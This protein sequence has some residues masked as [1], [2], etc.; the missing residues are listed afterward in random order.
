MDGL[1]I[2]LL[3]FNHASDQGGL[4]DFHLVDENRI[5]QTLQKTFSSWIQRLID[6]YAL[7]STDTEIDQLDTLIQQLF[8]VC[9][10]RLAKLAEFLEQ[11]VMADATDLYSL[12]DLIQRFYAKLPFWGIPPLLIE[13]KPGKTLLKEASAFI[14]HQHFKTPSEQ[15]KAWAKLDKALNENTLEIPKT[16][17][18]ESRY[19]DLN[20]FR[21]TLRAFIFEA[22]ANAR[23][24]LLQTDL[25]PVLYILKQKVKAEEDQPPKTEREQRLSG[26]SLPVLLQAVWN[27]LLQYQ[28]QTQRKGQSGFESLERIRIV[29]QR[30]N[31]DLQNDDSGGGIGREEQAQQLIRGCL[32]GLATWFADDLDARLPVDPEQ[33]QRRRDDWERPLPITLHLDAI[34]FGVSRAR[35]HLQFAV[36]LD[37][38]DGIA[39]F[40]RLFR[41]SFGPTQA[42]R[43]RYACAQTIRLRWADQA[44][45]L[46]PAFQ[47]PAVVMTAL[48]F[49]ADEDEAQRLISQALNEIVLIDQL[50]GQPAQTDP[51]LKQQTWQLIQTYRAWLDSYLDHGY[52]QALRDHYLPLLRAYRTLAEQVLDPARTG[53]AELLRRFYKAFLVINDQAQP[54]DAYLRSAIVWG[55]SPPLIELTHAQTRFL[56]DSF[57]EVIAELALNR[58]GQAAF[59]QLLNLAEIHRPLAGLVIDP[60]RALSPAI[61]SFGLLHHLGVAPSP[62]KSLAVQTLLRDD[63]SDDDDDI[64]DLVR[65]REESAIV[66]R[67]LTDY[68]ALYPF[69]QD[70]LRILAVHVQQLA[71]ILSGVDRFLRNYLQRTASDWPAFHCELTVYSTSSSP[72]AVENRLAAW[73]EAVIETTSRDEKVRP[74]AL[75]VSHR[76][77]PTRAQMVDFIQQ[78]RRLYDI[79]FLFHFMASDLTGDIEPTLP[80]AFNFNPHNISPFPIGEYPRPIQQGDAL[81]RQSLLSHRRLLI[82]T[83]HANLSARL[84]HPQMPN[85]D[86]LI[87]GHT[88][89]QPWQP[90]VQALHQKAQWVACIDPYVDKRLVGRHAD[91]SRRKIVGFSSGLGA[92]GELN[93]AISTEQDTLT[94]LTALVQNHLVGLMPFQSS[95]AFEAMAAKVVNEAEEIIGLSSLRAVVGQGERIREVV[96]FAAIRRALAT[97]TV[98]MSQLLPVDTLLHWF[99]GSEDGQ[100]PDLLQLSLIVR[101]NG[102]P[103]IQALV[104]EC[105]FAQYDPTHLQKASQQV[106][107][108]LRHFTRRFAPNRPDSGR[109]S[110]D[111]RYWWAQLQRALTSRSVVA[112]SQQERGQLDQ[113]L[114]SLAEGYYEIAWQGAIFTFWTDIAGSTPVVTPIPLPAGVLEPPLQAPQGFALWHIALGYEGV[115]AL[116]GDAPTFAPITIDPVAVTL[117]P[118]NGGK[119]MEDVT[120]PVEPPAVATLLVEPPAVATLPVE[121]SRRSAPPLLSQGGEKTA[122]VLV[123][124]PSSS[125]TVPDQL[126]IGA[127]SNG[128][129]VYWHYGHPQLAN[130]H[131]LIF[132]AT[133]VGKTYGVQCLLAEMAQQHLRS[134]IIDYTDGF[135][136]S[137]IEPLFRQ[138]AKPQDHFVVSHKLPL[139]PFRQQQQVIDPSQPAFAETPFHTATRIAS[140]F[141]SVFNTMGDQ[142]SSTLIRVLETGIQ[143]DPQLT[144]DEVLARL[145]DD[146][147]YG[148]TLASKLEPL[149]R[150]QPFRPGAADSAWKEMLN[151]PER[152]VHV[153][154]LKGLAREIQ[155]LVTEFVLWDLYDY[156][157]NTGSK[158]CPIPV[159]LD[160]IQNLDHRSDSPIDKMLREGRKFGLSLILATQTTS[161]FNQEARDRL[162]QAGHK[163]F[164]KPADTEIERFAQL[165]SQSTGLSK[166]EW[167]ERLA[168]LEKGQCWS[169]GPVLT[170]SGGLQEKPV[171]A[172]VTPLE[173]R[174]LEG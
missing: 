42:E 7:A 143:D 152:R 58:P 15:K 113:A 92:Y 8:K 9:P 102:L 161:Q 120:P 39:P 124:L 44:P 136:P 117:S 142:Q 60:Q 26:S 167:G 70:G 61:K 138:A 71:T 88:D 91:P 166:G 48:Y 31:H 74:L 65:P 83:S 133:G 164:F 28:T 100:R 47:L 110:F 145:R 173:Q 59:A 86:A 169:F 23:E 94:Q 57:P 105:K 73:R 111:R 50:A 16:L 132:G 34:T 64:S 27:T 81:R 149:I 141:T 116:F 62:E 119:M 121:P 151:S 123:P 67:V 17:S 140:I 172:S 90:V 174:H 49:A 148:E 35:P 22:N 80:F 131:L 76:F 153:L 10:R 130:R 77:A 87:L 137:Q 78:E 52:Y 139:N 24:R 146:K 56:C 134:I 115:T 154:Q 85:H 135:L 112:L 160:E 21:E 128:E 99:A 97:P 162:F 38:T 165:L 53:S 1:I 126:L 98:A 147:P 3:G 43:V 11:H 19:L 41:W 82:Q 72:L 84:C 32:G 30:F 20:E 79:A 68:Q 5:W 95:D 37:L 63:D 40:K 155:R 122:P 107:Q 13:K 156:A 114:E 14:A 66:E 127:R 157:C 93:L 96:G 103:L 109:V 51:E 144:L 104:L 45:N 2:V 12:S 163:L 18:T 36:N 69:A 171:L 106:Q 108:G 54:N 6:Q 129:P 118:M 158:N 125:P 168:R 89:Y 101:D 150:S 33:A 170:S 29:I 25:Q 4:A 75:S 46:L 55:L 159:V